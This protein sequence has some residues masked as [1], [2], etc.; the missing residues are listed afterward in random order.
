MLEAAIQLLLHL[1][2][3]VNRARR[4]RVVGQRGAVGE[5]ERSGQQRRDVGDALI[6]RVTRLS[7]AAAGQGSTLACRQSDFRNFSALG[8]SERW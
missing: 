6:G 8:R 2:E 3:A 7:C 1:I 4:I 5:L